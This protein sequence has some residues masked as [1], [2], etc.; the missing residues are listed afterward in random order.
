MKQNTQPLWCLWCRALAF[1]MVMMCA[2]DTIASRSSFRRHG[3]HAHPTRPHHLH[4]RH[5]RRGRYRYRHY[6]RHYPDSFFSFRFHYGYPFWPYAYNLYYYGPGYVTPYSPGIH[7]RFPDFR[8]P[9]FFS[10]PGTLGK[11]KGDTQLNESVEE[12]QVSKP[13]KMD[14]EPPP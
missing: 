9:G 3:L 6:H 14:V 1:L 12:N 7:Q 4:H 10:Y 5:D 13:D 11:V 2:E 8:H